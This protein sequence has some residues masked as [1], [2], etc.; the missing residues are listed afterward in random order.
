MLIRAFLF[1]FSDDV[2]LTQLWLRRTGIN[3][4]RCFFD[5]GS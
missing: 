1:L 4:K 3:K 2:P 5:G